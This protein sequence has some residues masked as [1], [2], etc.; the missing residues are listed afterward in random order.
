MLDLSF[1]VATRLKVEG[2]VDF[3]IPKYMK[4]T[5]T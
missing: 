2:A 5:G 1:L 3:N 4:W